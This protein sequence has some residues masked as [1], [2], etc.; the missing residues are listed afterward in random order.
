MPPSAQL[1]ARLSVVAGSGMLASALLALD[2]RFAVFL[3]L[4]GAG[5]RP[6]RALPRRIVA[7]W[8]TV[9]PR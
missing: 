6:G 3:D 7:R 8:L 1:P 9:P 5:A 4:A 2:A